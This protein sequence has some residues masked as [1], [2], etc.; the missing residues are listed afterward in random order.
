MDMV[1]AQANVIAAKERIQ[2]LQ[3]EG[4][5]LVIRAPF[6]GTITARYAEPGAFV[7]PTTSASTNAGAT[8]SAVVELSQGLEVVARVPESDIGRI[9]IGQKAQIRVDAFPDERFQARV[10][11]IAPR[12]EKQDN[13][14][15]IPARDHSIRHTGLCN[16][17]VFRF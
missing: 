17:E 13:V 7:T 12:A 1:A 8:S 5:Q 4:R 2:Q 9:A 10:S 6:S 15:F 3:E 16:E 11:E 14:T